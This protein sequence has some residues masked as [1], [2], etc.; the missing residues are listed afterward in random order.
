MKAFDRAELA[1]ST[2]VI[3]SEDRVVKFQEVDAAGTIYYARVFEYFGDLSMRI[4]AS[5]GLDVAALLASGRAAPLAHAEADYKKPL[6]FGTE[7]TVELVKAAVGRTSVTLGYR[8]RLRDGDAAVTGSTS[9]V[10]IDTKTF[11]PVDVPAELAAFLT[12]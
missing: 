7:V 5:A 2:D 12:R 6:F 9:H 11:S 4:F 8:I 3:V 10:F 1:S